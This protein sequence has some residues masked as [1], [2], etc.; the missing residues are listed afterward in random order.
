MATK[1]QLTI[2]RNEALARSIR[3]KENLAALSDYVG[4]VVTKLTGFAALLAGAIEMVNPN[5]HPVTL[6]KPES[7][8]AFGLALLTGPKIISILAK[9]ANALK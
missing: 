4:F 1:E 6:L 3:R 5:F 2:A 8:V 9:V 7:V